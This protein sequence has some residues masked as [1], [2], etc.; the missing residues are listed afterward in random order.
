M[1]ATKEQKLDALTLP[2]G[3]SSMIR[4]S[5]GT[6]KTYT[7]TILAVRLL[8]G[9]FTGKCGPG[10]PFEPN[11]LASVRADQ[12]LIVTFTN[13]AAA[14]LRARVRARVHEARLCFGQAAAG[15]AMQGDKG[16]T[17]LCLVDKL[18]SGHPSEDAR[19]SAARKC[20]KILDQAEHEL[21]DAAICTIH[22]FC[23]RALTKVFAF[24]SGEPFENELTA[25]ISSQQDE[26]IDEV[27]RSLFYS[28]EGAGDLLALLS[29]GDGEK[30][31][32]KAL[33]SRISQVEGV[34]ASEASRRPQASGGTRSQGPDEMFRGCRISGKAFWEAAAPLKGAHAPLRG[35]IRKALFEMAEKAVQEQASA[36]FAIRDKAT[37]VCDL[38]ADNPD[39]MGTSDS[40]HSAF[41]SDTW[42]G[43]GA[44]LAVGPDAVGRDLGA[45]AGVGRL[46]TDPDSALQRKFQEDQRAQDVLVAAEALKNLCAGASGRIG[47]L[48]EAAL[49]LA[50]FMVVERREEICKRDHVLSFD[51]LITSLDEALYDKAHGFELARTL[52]GKY[53]VAMIDESQDTDPVQ[54][55]IFKRIYL[56]DD[57]VEDHARCLFIG[58]PKQSIYAFRNADIHSYSLAGEAICELFDGGDPARAEE[59]VLKLPVNYRSCE[60]VVESVND[61]F[62]GFSPADPAAATWPFSEGGASSSGAIPFE[63]SW[64]KKEGKLSLKLGGKAAGCIVTR[65]GNEVSGNGTS[66]AFVAAAAAADVAA[67]LK[68][69]VLVADGAERK[70][71]PSD[72][73]IIV[74]K[75]SQNQVIAAELRKRGIQSVYFSDRS[76]V[77]ADDPEIYGGDLRVSQAASDVLVLMDAMADYQ[78]QGKVKRLMGTRLAGL[79]ASGFARICAMRSDGEELEEETAQLR[80]GRNQWE[81]YGFLSAFSTWCYKHGTIGRIE[82]GDGG[83]RFIT[84]CFHIAELVQLKRHEI[85]G[86]RA[87]EKWLRSHCAEIT[88]DSPRKRLESENEQVKVYTMHMS[89]GLEFPV[90]FLPFLWCGQED[91][92]KK[93]EPVRYYDQICSGYRLDLDGS[94]DSVKEEQKG[95]KEEACRRL[96][97]ALTRAS[98]A[99]FIYIGNEGF[100]LT[101]TSPLALML[102]RWGKA[103]GYATESGK[104]KGKVAADNAFDHLVKGAGADNP[105]YEFR[106]VLSPGKDDPVSRI[107]APKAARA[108]DTAFEVAS[109]GM[110]GKGFSI[111]SYTA[112]TRGLHDRE[113]EEGDTRPDKSKA[114]PRGQGPSRFNFPR[115]TDAG[116]FLHEALE[117]FP[118]D[119]PA[120][121]S[122][123]NRFI[124]SQTLK[125]RTNGLSAK[126][127]EQ[128]APEG[129]GAGGDLGQDIVPPLSDWF[130]ELTS[131]PILDTDNGTLSLGGL[132]RGCWIPEMEYLIPAK[133]E[134]DTL[135]INELCLES[136]KGIPG[137]KVPHLVLDQRTL[138]GYVTGSLDLVMRLPGASPDKDLYFVADYK[139]NYLG[140]DE[141]FYRSDAVRDNVF[142]PH[143]RYD[144]QYLFYTLALHRFLKSRLGSAYSYERNFGG[145]LYLYL[146]GLGA[147]SEKGN[148]VFFTKPDFRIVQELDAMFK[149]E[150]E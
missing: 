88:P 140:P 116:T 100:S 41:K 70:V 18:L 56:T 132:R 62:G 105:R 87:Q 63:R 78:V 9:D 52:R 14:E 19:Q 135:R 147:G 27:W 37:Q 23:D 133:G 141:S 38:C 21:D 22:S 128:S 47:A 65:V 32:R 51:G 50:A 44:I 72:I 111:S 113:F 17:L 5:A 55:S 120:G 126:W 12:L 79:G 101:R 99:N 94:E 107:E 13:A 91:H 45:G 42:K 150:E 114:A 49:T 30:S 139:S 137:L 8:L 90:V 40:R 81:E 110:V 75:A 33:K 16:D 25:D 115:G 46:K 109:D 131:A 57:A 7:I 11:E 1:T 43:L 4:A 67:C 97:V 144:V 130:Q 54:Y 125:A 89:K 117:K 83:E 71:R 92:A 145:V 31:L 61:I 66:T 28:G 76:S 85:P 112:V 148:G 15:Q 118:F 69:G 149:G 123:F 143:N 102:S 119:R 2:L 108:S 129:R 93:G 36:S 20:E 82:G 35:K 74:S 68:D 48:R 26:A 29:G 146:R 60:A 53:P 86:I 142:D 24:E 10:N 6:G 136:A 122:E 80:D 98:A 73:T 77:L 84:D 138:H 96:Y 58:D 39:L 121:G 95:E 127:A 134:V 59:N 106:K 3:R 64:F 104:E 34:R 124:I 103:F